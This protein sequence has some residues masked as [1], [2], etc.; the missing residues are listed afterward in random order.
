PREHCY[1]L[2]FPTRRSSDLDKGCRF[3]GC[4]RPFEWTDAHHLTWWSHGGATAIDNL[5][6]LCRRHHRAVH[7]GGWRI[8]VADPQSNA[9]FIEDRKSTRL[10]SSHVSISYA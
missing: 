1:L 2:S 9:V 7:E 8:L 5:I 10:N 3:P 4:H 6:L